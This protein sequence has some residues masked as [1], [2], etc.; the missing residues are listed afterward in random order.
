MKQSVYWNVMRVFQVAHPYFLP[1]NLSWKQVLLHDEKSVA[2]WV[3]FIW[4]DTGLANML[5]V[6]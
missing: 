2:N 5:Q 1:E 3:N 6:A 4:Y